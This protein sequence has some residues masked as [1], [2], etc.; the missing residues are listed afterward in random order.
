MNSEGFIALITAIIFSVILMAVALSLNASGYFARS[1]ILDA[2][3]KSRST[4]LAEACA[5]TALLR[6]AKNPAYTGPEIITVANDTCTIVSVNPPADP[7]IVNAKALYPSPAVTSQG[8]VTNLKVVVH[9][10]DLSVIS[11]E[12]VAP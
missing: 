1:E 6:L 11:W 2:E 12:E 9:A 8:A 5:D 3:Y 4:A 10:T 7:I